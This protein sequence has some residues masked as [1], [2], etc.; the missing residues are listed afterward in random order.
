M[1]PPLVWLE[2]GRLVTVAKMW[3]DPLESCGGYPPQVNS[4]K[5]KDCNCNRQVGLYTGENRRGM[6]PGEL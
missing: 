6:H 5:K 1:P 3:H 2:R 4:K